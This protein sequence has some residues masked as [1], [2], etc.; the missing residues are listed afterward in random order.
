MLGLGIIY[1]HITLQVH[2]S[3]YI[4]GHMVKHG[5]DSGHKL[6]LS[7]ADISVWCYACDSY[8]HNEVHTLLPQYITYIPG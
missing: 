3:R 5:E 2:C 6:V 7:Y 1:I 8:I 4:K